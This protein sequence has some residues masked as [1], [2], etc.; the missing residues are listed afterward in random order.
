MATRKAAAGEARYFMLRALGENDAFAAVPAAVLRQLVEAASFGEARKGRAIYEA[1]ARWEYLGF[2][3]DGS[4]AMFAPG[5]NTKARLYEHVY[6][7]QFFGISAMFDGEPEMA[8]TI[9]VSK[10]ATYALIERRRA[11]ELCEINGSLAVAFAITLARR[12]RRTTSL[13]A[14]QMSLTAQQRI[15][16]YLLGFCGGP[17]LA[18]ALDPLPLMTQTQIGAAAGTVKEVVARAVSLFERRGALRRE[19]GRIHF[20]NRERL[21]ELTQQPGAKK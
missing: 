1:G 3:V 9:V 7:G 10:R 14:V 5:A 13:L 20:L 11:V 19:R 12:V 18:P 17:G 2:V 4:M 15:A 16:H 6:P 8:R 21:L